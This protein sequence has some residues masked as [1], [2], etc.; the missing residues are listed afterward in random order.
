MEQIDTDNNTTTIDADQSTVS[1]QGRISGPTRR[2]TKGG[3]TEEEDNMLTIAVQKFN[4]KNWKKIGM[5]VAES[6]PHRTDVQCLHRW[7]KVLNPDLVKGPWTKEEDDLIFELVEKQGKKKWS[8]I[9]KF[10]PGRIGKQCRE[11]WCNHLNPDI[12]KTA[13]TVDEELILISAHG[14]YG[15][16]WAEIAKLLPGRT[17]NS[18]KNHWNSSVR[19]KVDAMA[20]SRI[21]AVDHSPKAECIS[22]GISKPL[23]QNLDHGR[24]IS[25][26]SMCKDA[27]GIMKPSSLNIS[28]K[29]YEDLTIENCR[30]HSYDPL[31]R[32]RQMHSCDVT[33]GDHERITSQCFLARMHAGSSFQPLS[34]SLHAPVSASCF[35]CSSNEIPDANSYISL[36]SI[37]R[38]AA[39]SFK[40]TPSIIR[41]RTSQIR[42]QADNQ[43]PL[44]PTKSPKLEN[45]AHPRL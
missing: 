34:D 5:C 9:A 12:K 27:N 3:W 22:L 24:S 37:L 11:R 6:V 41:K 39:K 25:F 40:N 2:S 42:T 44:S 20:A 1:V 8:E 13:W 26:F 23:E 19:K 18:I 4:G 17:E 38:S 32:N 35:R 28:I 29:R 31:P 33:F 45:K 7:Q 10:L 30:V 43:L 21:N 16:R 14:A 36:E 15:N